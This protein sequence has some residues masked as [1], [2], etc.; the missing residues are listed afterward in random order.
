MA[1][2]PSRPQLSIPIDLDLKRR[3]QARLILEGK[4]LREWVEEM[5]RMYLGEAPSEQGVT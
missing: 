4:T 3:L 5:A 2:H 1:S